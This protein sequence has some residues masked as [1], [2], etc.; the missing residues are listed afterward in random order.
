[1]KKPAYILSIFILACMLLAACGTAAVPPTVTPVANADAVVAEGHVMPN[2]DLKLSFSARGK[3]TEIL[4][5]EGQD[6]RK[7]DVLVRL[8]D[9]EP[10]QAAL[11]A[12]K[13]ELAQAQQANDDFF[14]TTSLS[15]AQALSAYQKAQIERSK[16]QLVW[17]AIDP[18]KVQ[19]DIDTAQ[20]DVQDNK[21]LLDDAN[22]TLKKYLDLKSDNPTRRS[23]E[24][25]VRKAES[26]YNTA[27]RK[28][29][30]LQ[31]SVDEP[32]AVLDA[33]LAAETEA[34]R[35]YE[36]TRNGTPDPDKKTIL[37]ARLN[38]ATA[39]VAAAQDAL[40]NY[41]LKAPFDGTVTD[42][43]VNL[44]ELIGSE[45]FAIQMAD[46]SQWFIETSDLTELEVVKIGVG[47]EVEIAPDALPGVTLKGTILSISQSSKTQGGDVL[48][49]V[50]IKLDDTDPLLRWGMTVQATF[51]E[52]AK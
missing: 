49:T 2:Q 28:V 51:V 43:N 23:A 6:V 21:K 19:D 50:K 10:A 45:K 16:A 52:P 33:A 26:D 3:I 37:G 4:V 1:M 39:Q 20:T 41:D 29:E 12:A 17:D 11:A 5:S 9:S 36:N 8:G 44:G 32:R 46:T 38:N 22:D 13:L 7:G 42:V 27:I 18:N 47:Q 35:T 48:Y 34:R 31:R 24:D 14:R 30:E 25:D 15:S 40:D